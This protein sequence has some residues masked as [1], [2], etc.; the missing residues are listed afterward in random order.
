[1]LSHQASDLLVIYDKPTLAQRRLHASIAV[2]LK[3]FGEG[4]HHPNERGVVETDSRLI[5]IGLACDPHQAASFGDGDAEGPVTTDVVALL[6]RGPCFRAPFRYS[7][8]SACLPTNR[9][10]AA[11]RASYASIASA[12]TD[13]SSKAPASN[14]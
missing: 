1:M 6:S 12:A 4:R 7:I 11:I 9:S 10:S 8:S 14:F 3:V 5:V 2:S 13:S